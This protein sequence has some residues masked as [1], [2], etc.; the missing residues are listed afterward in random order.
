[1]TESGQDQTLHM[2]DWQAIAEKSQRLMQEF[3]SRQ[4]DTSGQMEDMMRMGEVFMQASVQLM[5]DPVKLAEAQANLWKGYM[6]LWQQTALRMA[7]QDA[8]PV[9][10][11]HGDDRRF[12]DEEWTQNAVF[13]YMK[14][15]YLL[16]SNWI[17][18]LMG[19]VDGLEPKT[20]KKLEFYTKLYADALSPTNFAATNPEVLRA[21]AETKGENLVKG[22]QNLLDDFERGKGQLAVKMVNNDAFEIAK[23]LATTPGKVVF[24][25][26][27]IQLIQFTP[28]TKKVHKK[29]LLIVPPWINKYYILDL[30]PKNSFIRWV[31]EQGYTAFV[32]SWVNPDEKLA[33]KTFDDYMLEGPVAALDAVE[34]ATG[35]SS[36][37][38]LGYCI[39]GTLV[40]CTAAY[41]ASKKD[42]RLNSA[43]FLTSLTDFEQVGEIDVF[44][45]EEQVQNLEKMMN[46]R[47]YLE[48]SEMAATFNTLRANDLVWS[49][50]INNYLMGKEPFPF[51]ILFWNGDSTRMPAAM[52]SAYLR[53]LYLDNALSKGELELDGTM[54]DLTKVKVPTYLLSTREDHIAPWE[55]TYKATQLY[56]GDTTFTLA[57]SGH[58]AGVINPPEKNKY[59]FWTNTENP[60]DPDAWFDS[61]QQHEGSWWPNWEAW[62]AKQSGAMVAAREPGKGKLKAIEDA[63]GSYVKLD[64]RKTN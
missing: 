41:L 26:D 42:K 6:D 20:K 2:E 32:V 8:E 15:S 52:H 57:A 31:V 34:K 64:L 25:N 9:V 23:D 47:G 37:N 27:L 16:S 4:G 33:K 22:L 63:P 56:S 17:Q 18:D 40:A 58:V 53:R 50:V 59:G 21:T 61:A 35:E 46:E 60:A 62:L 36:I 29:P 11:P 30:K 19:G 51:D 14:Q 7:G 5:S 3:A 12:K 54:L 39:G 49:F 13:D 24:Q 38:I 55:S 45:D 1:M 28:T 44:I 10:E 48:G 43:T